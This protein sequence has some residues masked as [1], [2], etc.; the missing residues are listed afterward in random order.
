MNAGFRGLIRSPVFPPDQTAELSQDPES[1]PGL[2]ATDP[3]DEPRRRFSGPRPVGGHAPEAEDLDDSAWSEGAVIAD[4]YLLERR[5]GGGAMGEVFLAQDRLLKKPVALKVLKPVLA[6][7][8]AT[9]RRFLREVALAHSVTHPNVVRIYDTGEA[10]GLPYFSM[11]YLQGQTLDEFIGA[12]PGE[13]PPMTLRE[14]R[15][16][17]IEILRGLEAA[18]EVGVIHRDLKPANARLTHRGAIVMDFGVAGLDTLPSPTPDP[19]E[20]RSLIRTEAG[21]IFGSPAY[22]APELWE[23]APATI[24]S[25]LY[26]FGVMVYQLLTGR[27]PFEADSTK[28]FLEQLRTTRPT[29]VR[30]LRKDTPRRL[31]NL[32]ARCMAFTAEERPGSAREAARLIEP[33]SGRRR[34]AAVGGV[35]AGLAILGS[36]Y[37]WTRPAEHAQMGL[38][39]EVALADLHGVVR[40]WDVGDHAS[41][42]RGL[43]RLA[44]RSP[45]SAAVGFWQATIDH[46]L[47]DEHARSA[48]CAGREWQGSEPWVELALAACE[49][50]YSLSAALQGTLE[51]HTGSLGD[52]FLPLAV[53]DSLIPRLETA[54]SSRDE[55]LA[56]A[57]AVMARLESA[58]RWRGDTPVPIRW[59]I[60]RADLA[61]ALGETDRARDDLERLASEHPEAPAVLERVAWIH[62]VSGDR[63]RASTA[64]EAIEPLDPRPSLRLLLDEGRLAEAWSLVERSPDP[65]YRAGLVDTWCGYAFRFELDAMP[66]QCE[67]LGP[68]L[69]RALWNWMRVNPADLEVMDSVEKTIF[70][71]QKQLNLGDCFAADSPPAVLTHAPPPFE[72]YL[73]QLEISATLCAQDSARGEVGPARRSADQLLELDP[74]EPFAVLLDAQ[75]DQVA[76]AQSKARGRRAD[77]AAHWRDAD[78]T[79]PLIRRLRESV[80]E[81]ARAPAADPVMADSRPPEPGEP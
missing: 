47:G 58:P 71:R 51:R 73:A 29:P 66:A 43:E 39:D 64:A 8:R 5:L 46:E 72:T 26:S 17:G 61:V 22:M 13:L 18:H 20:A 19:S 14:L 15:D 76:G 45:D 11:E 23:G 12:N 35:A 27:L 7:N 60:A 49:P 1:T 62:T 28:A 55:V 34:F 69:T 42:R 56:E 57:R 33:L 37:A 78:P 41:A 38:P 50:S 77:V 4:R 9:V 81:T 25:D 74:S 24:Q 16:L 59:A 63:E 75:L 10:H 79:L 80:T 53:R 32:V 2:T 31:A 21:T 40:A 67:E 36:T 70:T 48:H 65:A 54:R 44:T 6:E 30:A 52:A 68:G 3:L